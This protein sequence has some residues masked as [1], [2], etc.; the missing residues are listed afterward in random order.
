M[1]LPI[2]DL[3]AIALRETARAGAD[4]LFVTISG[5]HLYGF[6]S[7]D[8]DFDIRGAHLQPLPRLFSLSPPRDTLE[9]S[10]AEGG[11][12]IDFV[13]HEAA[14]FFRLMLGR[15]GYVL[16]Q[17]F[18]PLVVIGG[19][20]LEELREIAAGCI[21][22]GLHHH[23]RGFYETQIGM[24][25]RESPKKAK[26]LLYVY[27]VLLTGIHVLRHGR[28][29]SNL[30]KLL[31]GNELA[32]ELGE[33]MRAK[34]RERATLSPAQILPHRERIENLRAELDEALVDSP[35]PDVPGA[36]ADLDAFLY[37]LRTDS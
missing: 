35:L 14:K 5:A 13:S 36:S 31:E 1:D 32:A 25:E 23:Y 12:D 18:S 11:R 29:E 17:V 9:L 28:I 21:T 4:P 19:P 34:S 33:L 24:H 27:R 20:R 7:P 2:G 37:R 16:E 3:R 10:G 6:A 15:N 22:K 26:T 30:G 8:S